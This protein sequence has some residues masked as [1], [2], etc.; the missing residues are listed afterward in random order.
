MYLLSSFLFT[1]LFT[2]SSV[3]SVILDIDDGE[4]LLFNISFN[5]ADIL[6]VDTPFEYSD[7]ISS[8]RPTV[9]F[10]SITALWNVLSLFR[11]TDNCLNSLYLVFRFLL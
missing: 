7:V 9:L 4:Y 11:G 8:S 10:D 6:L 2:S 1:N 3:K 5:M